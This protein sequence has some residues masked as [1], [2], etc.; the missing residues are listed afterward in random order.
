MKLSEYKK[1]YEN[2]SAK[3]SDISRNLSFAGIAIVWIFRQEVNGKINIST[4]LKFGLLFFVFSLLFDISQ[5]LYGSILWKWFYF[6]HENNLDNLE[7]DPEVFGKASYNYLT[8]FM[9]YSKILLLMVGYIFIII[10]FMKNMI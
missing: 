10:F 3:A 1:V 7:E 8:N 6:K 4:C 2:L 5:Y 9:Y